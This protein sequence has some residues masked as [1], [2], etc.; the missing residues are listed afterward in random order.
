MKKKSFLIALLLVLFS[1]SAYSQ[2]PNFHIYLCFG[3]SNMEG[4]GTIEGQDQTVDSRLKIL[5]AVSCTGKPA[6]AWRTATPPLCRC[7]TGLGPADYFGRT[8]VENMPSNVTI[9]LVHVAVAGCK[10]ELFDKASYQSYLAGS[11]SWLRN[12]ANEY[13]G[14]PYGRLVELAQQAQ[15]DGVI[16]GILMHQGESNTGEQGATW[17]NKVNKVYNDLLRDLGLNAQD[18]PLLVGEVVGADQNGQCA[19]HNN[20]ISQINTYIPTA[21]AISSYGCTH[22]GDNLHFSSAGYRELGRRYAETMLTL[23]SVEPTPVA[24]IT[25]PANNATFEA[26]A[27]ITIQANASMEGGSISLVEFYANGQKIGQSSTAPYSYSWTNVAAGS[28]ELTVVATDMQGNSATSSA[29]SIRVTAPPANGAITI[30]ARGT[31]GG[32][33]ISLVIDGETVETWTDIASDLTEFSAVGNVNG[34][35]QVHFLNDD[36]QQNGR[37]VV[38]DYITVYGTRYE[39]EEQAINTALWNGTDCGGSNSE[40]M[41]CTGYIEFATNPVVVVDNC[42]NDPL[43]TDPGICGCGTPDIDSD[44]DLTYDCNDLC[45]NDPN[46]TEPGECG[47]GVEEGTCVVETIALT[48]G[49]NLIGYPFS[50]TASIESALSSVWA[51]VEVVKDTDSFYSI[52]VDPALN[53]LSELSY[54]KGYFIYVTSD[55]SLI[56]QQ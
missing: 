53:S 27:N 16:K 35:I 25:S 30:N 6:N 44:N 40:E 28:Y 56:W 11:E 47:C 8:M 38:V 33:N 46:K 45:P 48:S 1:I 43:K 37:D 54:A 17:P 19:S 7:S 29:V 22:G 50:G 34:V 15:Q 55:C 5:Q 3:Q 18:V 24:S 2:D 49:W 36:E 23:V 4:Q 31:Y 13:G 51:N 32:E 14:N 52:H 20:I 26:P 9:G 12:I 21:H 39:A 42:P 41:N 10:I